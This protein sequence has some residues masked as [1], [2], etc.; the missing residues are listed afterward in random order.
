MKK[1]LILLFIIPTIS[2]G[3]IK[4]SQLGEATS[5]NST[6]L[7]LLTQGAASKKLQFNT[8]QYKLFNTI[9][10]ALRLN[11]SSDTLRIGFSADSAKFF[12][13][14]PFYSFNKPI[15][16]NG[17]LLSNNSASPS[18]SVT[19]YSENDITGLT[20]STYL[21]AH[22]NQGGC[23]YE[24]F[25]GNVSQSNDSVLG[26]V[27]PGIYKAVAYKGTLVSDTAYVKVRTYYASDFLNDY[28]S[29]ATGEL[30]FHSG[31]DTVASLA[32]TRSINNSE[33]ITKTNIQDYS[34]A[35]DLN[36]SS[37][38]GNNSITVTNSEATL[39]LDGNNGALYG[40]VG[41]VSL[42]SYNN[43][44]QTRK[45]QIT[46]NGLDKY[47]YINSGTPSTPATF[48]EYKIDSTGIYSLNDYST[49]YKSLSLVDSAFVGKAIKA[50][51]PIDG[52]LD[53]LPNKYTPYADST[54]TGAVGGVYLGTQN[55]KYNALRVN[56]N[57]NIWASGFSSKYND[58]KAN[59]YWGQMKL[60]RSG[61]GLAVGTGDFQITDTTN[62]RH[63]YLQD[64]RFYFRTVSPSTYHTYFDP[65]VSDG[66]SAVA[67]MLGTKN[68]FT[69]SGSKL[70]SVKNGVTEKLHID[71]DGYI[72]NNTPHAWSVF[73]DSSISISLTQNV[74][75]QITN[76]TAKTSWPATEFLEFTDSGDT[77]IVGKS[78]D[79]NGTWN[80]NLQGVDSKEYEYRVMRRRSS[81][82]TVIWKYSITSGGQ[83]V[84]RN[85]DAYLDANA[86][87]KFWIEL[88]SISLA[89]GSV[90]I[91]GGEMKIKPIHLD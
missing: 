91:Y 35:T 24:W 65:F 75:Y 57:Q 14:Q 33:I 32:D 23:T 17:I 68:E 36:I 72:H 5:I 89:P 8:L 12:T 60:G 73:M 55:P 26:V 90:T 45:Q 79:Y 4:L 13:S 54:G 27:V 38:D 6:D 69:T 71:K 51:A 39:Y 19:A 77:L 49:R 31:N 87:D 53:G 76:Q 83:K 42:W 61:V 41:A 28:G 1:L 64:Y 86:G 80:V 56:W 70:L 62:N 21:H 50:N 20:A 46:L 59:L 52:I 3:Q 15:Y 16:A 7:F 25:L 66:A 11:Y 22:A 85:L 84:L 29:T 48:V 9:P 37:K 67:Y 43:D 74:W 44:S 82:N 2:Y 18:L 47:I 58:Y 40:S 34:L 10:Y 81:T 88:R 78:G 30:I 63:F